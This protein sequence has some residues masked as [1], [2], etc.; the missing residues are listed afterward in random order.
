L[1]GLIQRP[2]HIL[3]EGI[4]SRRRRSARLCA[5]FADA[6]FST[7][8]TQSVKSGKAQCEQMFSA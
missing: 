6:A 3:C 8:S 4:A 5:N 1:S 7:F 2:S